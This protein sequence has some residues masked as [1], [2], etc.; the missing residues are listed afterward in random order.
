MTIMRK[1]NLSMTVLKRGICC[2]SVCRNKMIFR[3]LMWRRKL[4][5]P[6][7][8]LSRWCWGISCPFWPLSFYCHQGCWADYLTVAMDTS[9]VFR[10]AACQGRQKMITQSNVFF[11]EE[12]KCNTSPLGPGNALGHICNFSLYAMNNA[13]ILTFSGLIC[14]HFCL[15]LPFVSCYSYT[16]SLMF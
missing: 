2:S 12:Q 1:R 4:L 11:T 16:L 6:E 9:L 5:S 14:A 13:I 7:V 15:F 8:C 3:F 10:V